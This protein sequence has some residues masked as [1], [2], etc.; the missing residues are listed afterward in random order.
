M[1]S[2]YRRSMCVCDV[3]PVHH[4]PAEARQP[5]KGD[6][7]DI[8]FGDG[9]HFAQSNTPTMARMIMIARTT[10]STANRIGIHRS[11]VVTAR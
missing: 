2:G 6:G 3:R 9:G 7:F 5:A 4:L 11:M 8:G 10:C 1:A